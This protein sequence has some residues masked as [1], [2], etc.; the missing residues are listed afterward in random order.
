[1]PEKKKRPSPRRVRVEKIE[2]LTP[3]VL[4][5]RFAGEDLKQF[6]E[7]K[8]AAH[9][10]LLFADDAAFEDPSRL[11]EPGMSRP[12]A[13]TYTPRRFDRD[14]GTIDVEFILHGAA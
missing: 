8:P 4:S 10:K 9:L 6:S 12:T 3:R 2:R 13:R 14:A 7:P 11:F 5:I 1:M